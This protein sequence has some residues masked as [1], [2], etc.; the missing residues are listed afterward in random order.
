MTTVLVTYTGSKNDRFDRSHYV[1]VHLPMAVRMLG[2]YG[3]LG[4]EAFFPATDNSDIV[5]ACTL[6][7]RDDDSLH[8]AMSAPEM[9]FLIDDLDNF[10]DLTPVQ[11]QLIAA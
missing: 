6:N 5:A 4:A 11:H 1:K 9:A 8:D 2:R 3:L 10:T 7:F